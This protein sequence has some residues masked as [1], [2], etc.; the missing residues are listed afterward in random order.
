MPRSSDPF[1]IYRLAGSFKSGKSAGCTIGTSASLL[2]ET[3]IAICCRSDWEACAGD[4]CEPTTIWL[5]C[6]VGVDILCDGF[7][8]DLQ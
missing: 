8:K 2:K 3:A 5:Y 6:L 7:S 1:R 4:A